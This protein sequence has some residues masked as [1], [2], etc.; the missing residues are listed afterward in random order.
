MTDPCILNADLLRAALVH[1][2]DCIAREREQLCALDAAAG[3]GDL[4]VTLATGFGRN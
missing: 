2:C 1:T 3:D 4:G